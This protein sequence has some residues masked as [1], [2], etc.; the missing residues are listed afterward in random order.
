MPD[1]QTVSFRQFVES[2]ETELARVWKENL[3]R[4]ETIEGMQE[5]IDWLTERWETLERKLYKLENMKRGQ[6]LC[7]DCEEI[8]NT[9]L[10]GDDDE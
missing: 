2:E 4:K 5:H 7:P 6:S 9:P 10:D 8:I 1:Y 3:S